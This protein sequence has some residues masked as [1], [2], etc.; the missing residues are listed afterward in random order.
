VE[1]APVPELPNLEYGHPFTGQINVPAVPTPRDESKPPTRLPSRP[2][3][4]T[5]TATNTT[6]T[7]ATPTQTR[8]RQ[9]HPP[10]PDPGL[11]PRPARLVRDPTPPRPSTPKP[12][13]A[14]K[15]LHDLFGIPLSN[16]RK[17]SI[18]R[19]DSP[20]LFQDAP[21]LPRAVVGLDFTSNTNG[22][23]K[24]T[25]D[26]THDHT[27]S[28]SPQQSSS[29]PPELMP[30]KN[31]AHASGSSRLDFFRT[32]KFFS[33]SGLQKSNSTRRFTSS[34]ARIAT[35][36]QAAILN[37]ST[38]L[39]PVISAPSAI[40]PIPSVASRSDTHATR[41]STESVN[42]SGPNY[43]NADP[44][45]THVSPGS[46]AITTP[47]AM[48]SSQRR[49]T[50]S[51]PKIVQTPPT[52]AKSPSSMHQHRNSVDMKNRQG[53]QRPLAVVGEGNLMKENDKD[54]GR[55]PGRDWGRWSQRLPSPKF[56]GV[57]DSKE[58]VREKQGETLLP[59]G[60]V[61]IA[62]THNPKEPD[63]PPTADAARK[64]SS[65][66]HEGKGVTRSTSVV[67][68]IRTKHGSFDFEKPVWNLGVGRASSSVARSGYNRSGD[69]L[70]S[71]TSNGTH[72]TKYAERG[73]LSARSQQE[74]GSA[75]N[76]T[77]ASSS[78]H[79]SPPPS[80]SSH[81]TSHSLALT[82]SGSLAASPSDSPA[83]PPS[84]GRATGKR[85]SAV[86]SPNTPAGLSHPPFAFEPPVPHAVAEASLRLEKRDLVEDRRAE[87]SEGVGRRASRKG[88]SLDL[89]L[90]L[91]WA[92]TKVR[93]EA[94]MSYGRTLSRE[95]A[96]RN[97]LY[98]R[99]K[100]ISGSDIT[101]A[102]RSVLGETGFA[103]FKKCMFCS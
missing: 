2:L 79:L 76:R 21:P 75:Y 31:K 38:P 72:S 73:V 56:F 39:R 15:K 93:E 23:N 69:S 77:P 29:R 49:P 14:R 65:R 66:G 18:S 88:H 37:L 97:A 103:K 7:P 12:S 17:S 71:G 36:E 10:I 11:T 32:P 55:K 28:S 101:H 35:S 40:S 87:M 58:K 99:D 46:T 85:T 43:E 100:S 54:R 61:V 95:S 44:M 68:N 81:T 64:A 1:S 52:P 92:P 34:P 96:M 5:T 4:S 50:T 19:P 26:L 60:R 53:M 74:N 51:I 47:R 98:E 80:T 82:K 45:P 83:L 27:P 89:G 62:I 25:P 8:H 30:P 94:L 67:G 20:E 102:F 6:I 57:K 59:R 42:T 13:N 70:K 84:L 90:G 33:G 24:L 3:S 48:S 9:K 86:R 78:N 16:S 22:D 91:A 63:R 41:Q